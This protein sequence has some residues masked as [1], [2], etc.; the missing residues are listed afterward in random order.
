MNP[1]VGHWLV[2]RWLPLGSAGPPTSKRDIPRTMSRSWPGVGKLRLYFVSPGWAVESV[3]RGG[4]DITD[5]PITFTE[6]KVV[7]GIE[8]VLKRQR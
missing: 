8:I 6:G 1:G 2:V 5:K 3:R 7:S 4:A